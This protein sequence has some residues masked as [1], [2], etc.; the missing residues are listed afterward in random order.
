L[1]LGSL[2]FSEE[3]MEGEWILRRKK[4]GKFWRVWREGQDGSCKSGISLSL[5]F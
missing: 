3:E 4:V 1:C 2:L 5:L